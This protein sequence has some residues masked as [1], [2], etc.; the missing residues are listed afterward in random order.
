MSKKNIE[1]KAKQ[2]TDCIEKIK[3]A[4][5]FLVFEYFGLDVKK[6]TKM[7]IKMHEKKASIAII[8]N[9]ILNRA[10][11]EVKIENVPKKMVGPNAI[12]FCNDDE[13]IGFKTV[14]DVMKNNKTVKYKFGYLENKIITNEQL[15][16]IASIPNREGLYSMVLSCLLGPI[17][18]LLYGLK[19][20]KK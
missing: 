14:Y 19:A 5:S 12:V 4:K 17:K 20:I 13:I 11:H 16:T 9:N 1:L 7:R 3:K 6:M 8:K 2:T 15:P 18:K 10:L